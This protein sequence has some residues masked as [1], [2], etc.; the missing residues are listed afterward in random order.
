M[1]YLKPRKCS[2][3][4]RLYSCECG[5]LEQRDLHAARNI[6][7]LATVGG[8]EK[9][10]VERGGAPVDRKTAAADSVGRKSRRGEAGNTTTYKQ[11]GSTSSEAA[12][13]TRLSSAVV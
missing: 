4:A 8:F 7:L 1:C 5:Y 10:P 6:L 3:P 2:P 11:A 12:V 13:E 9:T